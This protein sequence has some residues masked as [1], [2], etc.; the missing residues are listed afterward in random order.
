MLYHLKHMKIN[1]NKYF[2]LIKPTYFSASSK[3]PN[4]HPHDNIRHIHPLSPIENF[5]SFDKHSFM[6]AAY[7]PG[8]FL[9]AAIVRGFPLYNLTRLHLVTCLVPQ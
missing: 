5:Y 4:L 3:T 8:T 9:F 2:I 7:F 1:S 6:G